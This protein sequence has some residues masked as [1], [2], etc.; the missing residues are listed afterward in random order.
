MVFSDVILI[1]IVYAGMVT[2]T[3][4]GKVYNCI[5]IESYTAF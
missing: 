2:E 4:D 3:Y 1:S 5:D